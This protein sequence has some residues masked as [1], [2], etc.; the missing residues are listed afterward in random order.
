MPLSRLTRCD[1]AR[2]LGH[3]STWILVGLMLSACSEQ[4]PAENG[5][6]GVPVAGERQQIDTLYA[7]AITQVRQGRFDS[8]AV[9][10][11]Q[12]LDLD[13]THYEANLG[14]AEVHMRRDRHAEALA[15]LQQARSVD[16]RRPEAR[17]QLART[18]VRLERRRE[19]I[20]LLREL[21][22][23]L[24]A[25]VG[26]R[27]L[28]ADLLMTRK[29][30]DPEGALVQYE[31]ALQHHP[32]Y[33][34]ARAGAAASRL[35]V[36]Q[37]E[38][39]TTELQ[40]LVTETPGD[41]PLTFFLGTALYRQGQ[42]EAAVDAYRDA[43]DALP[44][45]S[46]R[47]LVRRWNLR[48][49]YLAAHGTYPGQ[50][51]AEYHL[52]LN[53]D[54]RES[55]VHFT[56]VAPAVGVDRVDRGRGNVWSDLDG[57]GSLDMFTVAIH[58]RHSLFRSD[59]RGGF[60]DLTEAADLADLSGGWSAT[61]ADYDNDGDADL[62]V[63]RDAWEGRAANSL[64]RNEHNA[65]GPLRFTD[66]GDAAG[67]SDPDDSFHA[68]WADVDG[69]GWVD[70]Y[71]ADGIT[72]TGAANKLFINRGDGRFDECGRAM[73]AAVAG[74]TLGVAFG[75]YDAD[76][77]LDLY[78]VD[79]AGPNTLLRND[80]GAGFTDVTTEAGV[81][82]PIQASY[83]SFFT[84]Y[85]VDGDL[86]LFVSTMCH[87]EHFVESQV[88]GQAGGPRAHLYRNEGHTRFTEVGNHVGLRRSFGSMGAGYGDIDYD[89]RV[90]L[91]LSNG[92][93]EMSRLEPN[94]L[95]QNREEGFADITES[96]GVGNL[97]KGH[98]ATF[99]D[100]DDD[101]DLDLYAG[102]GGHHP[103]DV[104]ANSLYR[105][106]GHG[107]HWIGLR[108]SGAAPNRGAIGARV[109]LRAGDHTTATQVT[110]GDGFGS[111]NS[112]DVE[113]G[114]GQRDRVD[115]VEVHWPSGQ[116]DRLGV[117]GVDRFHAVTESPDGR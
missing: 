3:A 6:K 37:L 115:A 44:P 103:G 114:L 62:Y 42:F 96:A 84:D 104:W 27:M 89:G 77:D 50:L 34:P 93:P 57:D 82:R 73:G 46:P 68:T 23:D 15:P 101:G 30:P 78:V 24:P 10:F 105:N 81:E 99:A 5:P 95:Y 1:P 25:H 116:I 61:A 75:D 9:L 38:R 53:D 7:R 76:G 26:I 113:L 111:G 51:P 17:M 19:A 69:D 100:F 55:P 88:T 97:G 13:D 79:V 8:A 4:E 33:R 12:V 54:A 86:D 102:I 109:V 11:G 16:P 22:A 45:D 66:A 110:S 85:D 32:E 40:T 35:R 47:R 74:R 67:V 106:D 20:E 108:L 59:G 70:L 71:V 2:L 91:Y 18:L 36:G 28:L 56:D 43:V 41:V 48:A 21:A 52:E 60:A 58:A 49:A 92:G 98:G 72:G 94:T 65:A 112:L 63:T 31:Q 64:Y 117:P 107:N 29:P 83:V 14:L 90:D 80:G 39:A 87:Y